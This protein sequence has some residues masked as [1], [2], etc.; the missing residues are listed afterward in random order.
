MV[1]IDNRRYF[2]ATGREW[3]HAHVIPLARPGCRECGGLGGLIRVSTQDHD[4]CVCVY[5]AAFR[6]CLNGYYNAGSTQG[7]G[8]SAPVYHSNHW[9]RPVENFRVDFEKVAGR[10]LS[11]DQ[12]VL[13]QRLFIRGDDTRSQAEA[14]ERNVIERWLGIIFHELEPCALHPLREY[15]GLRERAK[16]SIK[17]EAKPYKSLVPPL[18]LT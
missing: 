4:I 14:E 3:K 8:H 10:A 15:F 11:T 16:T 7:S 1:E 13:F 9:A 18:C 5:R 6:E 2:S 12:Y 17:P